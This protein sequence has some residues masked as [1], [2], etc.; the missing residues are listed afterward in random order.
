[1]ENIFPPL[2]CS[3]ECGH[4]CNSPD[5]ISR[6]HRLEMF[7]EAFLESLEADLSLDGDQHIDPKRANFL[8]ALSS[9]YMV[10]H[11]L[12]SS[13]CSDSER[14]LNLSKLLC[15]LALESGFKTV[16]H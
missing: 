8:D 11:F 3:C 9:D 16:T 12:C 2:P 14:I 15:E 5:L 7:Y 6:C 4:T 10:H 13:I 1:M